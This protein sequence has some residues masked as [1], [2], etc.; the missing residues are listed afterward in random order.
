[1]GRIIDID[2]LLEQIGLD[3]T[4]ENRED[5]VGEIITLEDLD[6]VP[7][8]YDVDKVLEELETKRDFYYQEMKI[9]ETSTDYFSGNYFDELHN[10]GIALNEAI[11]I[12]KRGG[13]EDVKTKS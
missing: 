11:K 5:N 12:V 8:A 7:T 13:T 4:E 3:D 9:A 2:D 6:R 1:M 10:K